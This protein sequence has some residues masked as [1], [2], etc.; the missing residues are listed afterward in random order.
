MEPPLCYCDK[1]FV[2]FG[3]LGILTWFYDII[4]SISITIN[5]MPVIGCVK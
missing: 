1:G 4:I 5:I 3:I 2:C